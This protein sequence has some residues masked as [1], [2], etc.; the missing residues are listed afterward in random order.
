M[1]CS[2]LECFNNIIIG[3]IWDWS[4]YIYMKKKYFCV[5]GP[6]PQ[7]ESCKINTFLYFM[8]SPTLVFISKIWIYEDWSAN[9][10]TGH[11][12]LYSYIYKYIHHVNV[13]AICYLIY[14]TIYMMNM[15]TILSLFNLSTY[16]M[17]NISSTI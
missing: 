11:E 7:S 4:H 14:S 1:A 15:N 17:M 2:Y 10:G 6:V 12:P 9:F 5:L 8:P 16:S 3:L 13:N